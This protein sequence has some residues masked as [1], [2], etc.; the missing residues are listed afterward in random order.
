MDVRLPR[1]RA[2]AAS[3]RANTLV[4]VLGLGAW[5][6]TAVAP[7]A[8]RAGGSLADVNAARRAAGNRPA[9]AIRIGQRIFQ[10]RW[11]AQVRKVRVDGV[12]PHLVAG[13]VLDGTKFHETLHASGLLDEVVA[14]V[15]QAFAASAV[16]EVDIW[17]IVPLPTYAGEVVAGD[18]AQPT[19][20]TVFAA[21]VRRGEIATFAARLRHGDDVYWDA[22]WRAGLERR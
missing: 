2:R 1:G 17:A 6:A 19:S 11:P 14:L 20:Y 16:E 7:T 5:L 9:E 10:T 22:T 13:I 3:R 8:A 12:G 18:L 15:D 4:V 21:T